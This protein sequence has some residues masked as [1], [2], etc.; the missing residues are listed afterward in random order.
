MGIPEILFIL[1]ILSYF[2]TL[3][4]LFERA[5]LEKWKGYVPILQYLTWLKM[6]KRPWYWLLLLLVP[7]VNFIMLAILNVE[8]AIVFNRRSPKDQ[9]L[10]GLL[11]WYYLPQ[12]AFKDKEAKYVGPREWTKIKKSFQREWGEAIV[13]A[14][15]AASVIRTFF[16]EAFTIPTPSMEDS[17]KVGDYLFVSKISYGPKSPMT[18]MSIPFIHNTIP[19][20]MMNSYVDWFSMPYFRLP[21][22]GHVERYDPVVFNF[23]HG[24]TIIVD[25]YYAGHDY[26]AILRDEAK[27]H[28]GSYAKFRENP[29]L[30]TAKARQALSEGKCYSCNKSGQNSR[31]KL[32]PMK[33]GGVKGRPIDKCENYVKRCI[34]LPGDDLQIVDQVVQINGAAI[35]NPKNSQF[36]YI[37]AMK[38]GSIANDLREHIDIT[39][40]EMAGGGWI[41]DTC[42]VPLTLADYEKVQRMPIVASVEPMHFD[43]VPH[44]EQRTFPN[45]DHPAYNSW[46]VDNYGPVHIPAQ[47]ETI[48]LDLTNIHLYK[49]AISV[50]EGHDLEISES[51]ISIDGKPAT[52]YTFAQN[53]YWMMGDN[54]HSSAD[55]RMWG[56]VPETHVVGKPV[57]VWFSKENLEQ[58]GDD[59]I[60]WDRI[61]LVD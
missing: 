19:G 21:G 4:A 54:R 16:F 10:A 42:L 46:T 26:Y 27:L 59:K 45:T 61:G 28:A 41:S 48:Q 31:G 17:M 58:H 9:C 60:R 25:S 55:S 13:F 56:F 20:S 47:G 51:G 22:I 15:V 32:S 44:N 23:P 29:D 34:G 36:L 5:G 53:Y 37:I 35:E 14:I 2:V 7:G 6:V 12:L 40:S 30:Y 57:F 11:P 8:T 33:T 24:D 43:P 52:S 38:G 50:Y 3:P 39:T 49:R 18:P 1:L